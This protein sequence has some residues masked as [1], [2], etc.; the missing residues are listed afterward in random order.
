[1]NDLFEARQERD[2]KIESVTLN[3]TTEF[4]EIV[5][6][7]VM[8]IILIHN[9]FTADDV[10]EE[11]EKRPPRGLSSDPRALGGV[12]KIMAKEG[13]IRATGS[14]QPSKR[15]H[16]APIMVWERMVA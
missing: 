14:W 2:K 10:W 15:R 16:A 7:I 3:A 1:M 8:T 4:H 9:H 12:L 6:E 5:R 13:F 11:F